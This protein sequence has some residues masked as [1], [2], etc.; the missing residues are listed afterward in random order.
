[1][2]VVLGAPGGA[3]IFFVVRWL[4]RHGVDPDR[5]ARAREWE[6]TAFVT[7]VAAVVVGALA[8]V[9]SPRSNVGDLVIAVYLAAVSLLLWVQSARVRVA[10]SA[11]P[12]T[13][14]VARAVGVALA[15]GLVLVVVDLA[16][17]GGL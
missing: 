4:E 6:L 7:L 9:A 11:A 13:P 15:I 5:S 2:A 10:R 3:C 12:F 16:T 1:M 14:I 8:S 17:G